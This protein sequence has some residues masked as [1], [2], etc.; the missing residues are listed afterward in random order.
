VRL[1]ATDWVEGGWTLEESIELAKLLR[2]EGVDLID[3]SSGGGVHNAVVPVGPGYQVPL[4]E[5]I[6]LGAGIA[7]AAVGLITAPE[8]ADEIIR[9]GRADIVLLGREMLRDPYWA[10]HAAQKLKQP[11]LS[12]RNISGVLNR[13]DKVHYLFFSRIDRMRFK[14]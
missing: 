2:L 4:S 5:A 12:R 8:Q 3:C 7:T 6:R 10:L 9:N 13:L 14:P 11:C 1:S